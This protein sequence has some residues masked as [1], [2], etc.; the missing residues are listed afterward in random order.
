[1]IICPNATLIAKAVVISHP[2]VVRSAPLKIRF[3][4]RLVSLT[5]TVVGQPLL[6]TSYLD[7]GRAIIEPHRDKR[8]QVEAISAHMP[9]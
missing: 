6:R 8:A 3:G 1:M 7:Y 9:L 5:L 2:L 4:K